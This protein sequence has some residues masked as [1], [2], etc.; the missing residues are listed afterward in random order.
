MSYLEDFVKHCVNNSTDTMEYYDDI[1]ITREYN[2]PEMKNFRNVVNEQFSKFCFNNGLF[3]RSIVFQNLKGLDKT[4][5]TLIGLINEPNENQRF[6][7]QRDEMV[8]K[9]RYQQHILKYY[10]DNLDKNIADVKLENMGID[11]LNN[12]YQD[13]PPI[14]INL[15]KLKKNEIGLKRLE[16][17]II[18]DLKEIIIIGSGLQFNI[19]GFPRNEMLYLLYGL[20]ICSCYSKMKKQPFKTFKDIVNYLKSFIQ[21]YLP[22]K[23]FDNCVKDST[24]PKEGDFYNLITYLKTGEDNYNFRYKPA[25]K[26]FAKLE[27]NN[28]IEYK[29]QKDKHTRFIK[30]GG[31]EFIVTAYH[32]REDMIKVWDKLEEIYKNK[33][34]CDELINTW[35]DGQ[36]LTRSTCLVGCMLIMIKEG[37]R[38]I[39]K[40][41]EMPD[42]KSIASNDLINDNYK[43]TYIAEGQNPNAPQEFKHVLKDDLPD[44]KLVDVLSILNKYVKS[45][46]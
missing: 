21:L 30:E 3:N 5:M 44:L 20:A 36:L 1:I 32:T 43:S 4:F 41:D 34:L 2:M 8:P 10:Y 6:S 27:S 46:I 31:K 24:N 11:F 17:K 9:N 16:S 14:Y 23:C 13:V 7:D 35:F 26:Y 28:G 37:K 12:Y 15:N 18:L 29:D 42:W 39:F 45:L 38:I 19:D 25:A 33:G 40:H 22:S